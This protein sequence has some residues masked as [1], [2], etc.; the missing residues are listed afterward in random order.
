MTNKLYGV[1]LNEIYETKGV[2]VMVA[3]RKQFIMNLYVSAAW[4][5]V[6]GYVAIHTGLICHTQTLLRM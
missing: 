5:L 6:M 4:M 1:T 2:N 3:N